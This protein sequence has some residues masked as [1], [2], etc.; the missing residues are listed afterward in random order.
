MF[1][2]NE[3]T[4]TFEVLIRE[5]KVNCTLHNFFSDGKAFEIDSN[6]I[7]PLP[8]SLE[9]ASDDKIIEGI[10]NDRVLFWAMS[11]RMRVNQGMVDESDKDSLLK[12]SD[13]LE[14][15]DYAKVKKELKRL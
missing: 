11:N 8:E 12:L 15:L 5:N 3:E 7:F 2:T 4:I 1:N 14:N 6:F 13:V 9:E 10:W